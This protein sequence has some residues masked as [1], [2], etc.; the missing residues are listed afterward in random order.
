MLIDARWQR[1]LIATL[2]LEPLF[3][4][5][6]LDGG[7]SNGRA[8]ANRHVMRLHTREREVGDSTRLVALLRGLGVG[9]DVVEAF[10]RRNDAIVARAAEIIAEWTTYLPE[11]CVKAMVSDGWHSS[12]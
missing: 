11:D 9:S 1:H 10:I 7:A 4:S 5:A 12:T 3:E 2:Q 8:L 6:H